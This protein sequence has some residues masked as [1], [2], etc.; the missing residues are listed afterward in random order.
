MSSP[1]RTG[2]RAGRR[3]EAAAGGTQSIRR[4]VEILRQIAT[5]GRSG[6]RLVD[7]TQAL[8]LQRSTAHRILQCLADEGLIVQKSPG[9]RYLL[10][11]LAFE[12]GL[13]AALREEL[14]EICRPSLQRIA[15]QSGDVAFLSVRS[16]NDS[17]CI[18]YTEGSYPV[19]AYARRI[20][21]RRP[22]GFGAVGTSMLALMPED[23]VLDIL[24]SGA[25]ALRKFNKETVADALA[26]VARARQRGYGF[27]ESESTS[28]RLRSIALAIRNSE[29]IP[30]AAF[31]ICTIANRLKQ[32]RIG[33]MLELIRR[34][35][36][37]VRDVLAA[38]ARAASTRAMKAG[39]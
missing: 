3:R 5:Y 37:F 17:V 7:V 25:S 31:S 14:R 35:I 10:G 22:L 36:R 33:E 8:K 30:F 11:P 21:D 38:N 6:V 26:H 27:Y 16:G 34:E 1:L 12:L 28:I 24:N 15:D 23:E 18:D 32:P 29:G 20:G 13:G 19:R 39:H 4:A 9:L 2:S